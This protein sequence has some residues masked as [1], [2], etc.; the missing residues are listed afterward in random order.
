MGAVY[1]YCSCEKKELLKDELAF[2]YRSNF[3][4]D[5]RFQ[6]GLPKNGNG[7]K[8]DLG[9]GNNGNYN[10]MNDNNDY[11][12][13]I[14]MIDEIQMKIDNFRKFILNCNAVEIIDSQKFQS[15]ITDLVTKTEIKL[16]KITKVKKRT[17]QPV[18]TKLVDMPPIF[19][20]KT[21]QLYYGQWSCD[22][23]NMASGR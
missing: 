4:L 16:N 17:S 23:K 15:Y 9:N 18:D 10:E 2:Y 21:G 22:G 12:S 3:A 11:G 5:D 19:F 14:S 7:Y 13:N 8:N 20:K 6:N 1:N